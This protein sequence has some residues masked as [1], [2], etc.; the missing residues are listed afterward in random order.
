MTKSRFAKKVKISVSIFS[1][2]LTVDS[3][4]DVKGTTERNLGYDNAIK[5]ARALK[6]AHRIWRKN[7]FLVERIAAWVAYQEKHNGGKP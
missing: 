2:T 4:A 6:T 1:R 7:G 3:T 5:V